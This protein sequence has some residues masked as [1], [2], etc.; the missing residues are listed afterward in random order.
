MGFYGIKGYEKLKVIYKVVSKAK[1][2]KKI[3]YFK[4]YT[5][6]VDLMAFATGSYTNQNKCLKIKNLD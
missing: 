1:I 2:K 6:K 5:T 4:L 3:F